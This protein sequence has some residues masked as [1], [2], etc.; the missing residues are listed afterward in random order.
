[1]LPSRPRRSLRPLRPHLSRR[2]VLWY[3][4]AAA[5]AILTAVV[6]H[7]ALDQAA[8]AEAAYGETRS[9][10]VVMQ[11]VEAGD[12]V[13]PDDV[14]ARRWPRSLV[15]PAALSQ[16][17]VGRTALVDL[18]P[19]EV[20]LSGRVGGDGAEGPAALLEPGQRALAVP[21]AVPGLPLAIGDVVDVLAGGA[22]GGGPRGDLPVDLGGADVVAT[23]ATVV[24]AGE[25]IAV[26][27]VDRDAAADIA[28]ALTTGPVVVALRPPGG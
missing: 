25:E 9:V 18:S 23:G 7:R 3:V 4:A 17:P 11:A 12:P 5:L 27:A 22:P 19:G 28:A 15:P 24:R 8:R 13:T 21:L 1:M 6:V 16:I 10:A 20:V 14:E 2:A 26:L